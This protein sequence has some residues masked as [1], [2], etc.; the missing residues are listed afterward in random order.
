[1]VI[2]LTIAVVA[3]SQPDTATSIIAAI[4]RRT[5]IAVGNVVRSNIFNTFNITGILGIAAAIHPIPADPH[6]ATVDMYLLLGSALT[7]VVLSVLLKGLLRIGGAK[8]LAGYAGYL[9]LMASCQMGGGQSA[10]LFLDHTFGVHGRLNG[11]PGR[12]AF[13]QGHD[14]R[15]LRQVVAKVLRPARNGE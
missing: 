7:R 13:A 8:L 5:K 6:F 11:G 10:P 3:T 9:E 4:R 1:M 12:D 2:G 14:F 15:E